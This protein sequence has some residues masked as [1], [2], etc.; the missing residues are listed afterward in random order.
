MARAQLAL[1]RPQNWRAAKFFPGAK[2]PFQLARFSAQP[3]PP[4]ADQQAPEQTSPEQPA[5]QQQP[6]TPQA[7]TASTMHHLCLATHW[8]ADVALPAAG[9]VQCFREANTLALRC[10]TQ[11]PEC[12]CCTPQ[13]QLLDRLTPDMHEKFDGDPARGGQAECAP[14]LPAAC[15]RRRYR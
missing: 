5:V 2:R 3:K 6:M 12:C 15:E 4:A 7:G 1:P 8:H 10:H 11:D 14:R 9:T 13:E